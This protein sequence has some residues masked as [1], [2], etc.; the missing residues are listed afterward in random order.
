[1]NE[2]KSDISQIAMDIA[3]KV[4]ERELNAD[5]QQALIEGFIRQMGDSQ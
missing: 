3:E 2:V 4:V 1:M 5:D